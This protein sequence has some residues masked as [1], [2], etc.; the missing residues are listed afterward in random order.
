MYGNTTD[1]PVAQLEGIDA[2]LNERGS[3]YGVFLDQAM[4]EQQLM[5]TMRST[6]GWAKLL[7]DQ[8]SA[9]EMMMV[10]TAR[11]LNGD[12]DYIDNWHDIIGYATLVWKRLS[13]K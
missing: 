8:R 4:I 9:L 3:R 12:P 13:G 1:D 10:K 7:S 6:P 11:I 2:T 5:N